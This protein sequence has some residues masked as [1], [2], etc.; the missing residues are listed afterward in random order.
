MLR[1]WLTGLA[2]LMALGE[3]NLWAPA[4]G[5]TPPAQADARES[6]R[7]EALIAR[8][9]S[10]AGVPPSALDAWDH[11]RY[12]SALTEV[13]DALSRCRPTPARPDHCLNLLLAASRLASETG[14]G[15]RGL[16]H[17]IAAAEAARAALGDEST[18]SA[19]AF[20]AMGSAFLEM[21]QPAE[22]EILFRQSL[23][24]YEQT[25]EASS[26]RR[27]NQMVGDSIGAQGRSVEAEPWFRRALDLTVQEFGERHA[28]TAS[29]ETGLGTVLAEQ[30][31]SREAEVHF[32]R[33]LSI[34]LAVHGEENAATA[35]SYSNVAFA[36]RAQLMPA[37][38]EPFARRALAIHRRVHGEL[39]AATA[40]DYNVLGSTLLGA[41]RAAES[42]LYFRHAL[43]I[44]RRVLGENRF[45]TA[46]SYNDL[47]ASLLAQRRS[48]E[49]EPYLRLALGTIRATL[50]EDHP[51]AIGAL[52]NLGFL[53]SQRGGAA[54]SEVV[55][56]HA[57]AMAERRLPASDPHLA[58]AR[59]HL[60][61]F[62]QAARSHPRQT[63]E[64]YRRALS[65]VIEQSAAAPPV[66]PG[67]ERE[68]AA[69]R[70]D[71]AAQIGAA[72]AAAAT[73]PQTAR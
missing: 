73:L 38:A 18:E 6:D 52:I 8:I 34:R 12:A 49:A 11:G 43:A 2:G 32:R 33:A 10:R 48:R 67:V 41:G 17:G 72:W 56:R 37:E 31:R 30:G 27:A 64:L 40:S 39:D 46:Q 61:A 24:I 15:E 66:A 4:L 60:A 55:F 58:L 68:L 28:E 7:S 42:E 63:Y 25:G 35:L 62:W 59:L 45:R 51:L 70:G 19:M 3:G 20:D 47:G 1:L 71:F 44:R 22:A 69:R 9:R 13:E 26:L 23:S 29:A 53:L 36:L 16:R 5:Q 50:G 14:D 57:A 65:Q 21:D 54:E